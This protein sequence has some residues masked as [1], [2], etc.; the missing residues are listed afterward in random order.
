MFKEIRAKFYVVGETDSGKQ[1]SYDMVLERKQ[2]GAFKYG[3]TSCH[4]L[5]LYKHDTEEYVADYLY[6]T[7]YDHISTDKDKW[8]KEWKNF[9]QDNWLNVKSV[10]LLDY[11]ENLVEER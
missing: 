4:T 8:L 6:D 1:Y 11:E 2:S 9:I 3:D 5:T 7:R 10:E